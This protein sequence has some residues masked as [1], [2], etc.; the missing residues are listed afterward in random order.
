[1]PLADCVGVK[2]FA[3]VLDGEL[4][5]FITGAALFPQGV[6][7]E[8]VLAVTEQCYRWSLALLWPRSLMLCIAGQSCPGLLW[9]NIVLPRSQNL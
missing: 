6:L 4:S 2:Q 8:H 7:S 3:V 5:A 9:T 1:M